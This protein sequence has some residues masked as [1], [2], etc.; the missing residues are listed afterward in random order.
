MKIYNFIGLA[1]IFVFVDQL[2]KFLMRGIYCGFWIF[3]LEYV[4][5]TGALFG[6]FQGFNWLFILIS[7]LVVVLVFY[8]YNR[9]DYLHYA[10]AVLL[11]GV[12]GNLVD[13]ILLG[14]VI[15]FLGI[16]IWPTFNFA[17]FFIVVA[18]VLI[19]IEVYIKERLA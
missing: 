12:V 1:F 14:H 4:E 10:F 9:Y 19:L 3:R 16:W 13:R 17:D 6:L 8:Y 7:L 18:V 15:D 5:N 11:G 2:F